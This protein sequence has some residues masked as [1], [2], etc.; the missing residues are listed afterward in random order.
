MDSDGRDSTEDWLVSETARPPTIAE[1]EQRIDEALAAAHATESAITTIG[2]AAIE[3]TEQA[4]AAVNQSLRAAEQAHR[5]AVL[6]ELASS[7]LLDD[8]HTRL[9]GVAAKDDLMRSFSEHA[10]RVTARL[11]ALERLPA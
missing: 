1:L 10:D 5:S 2:D 6:A 4:R 9:D 7:A 11:R 3:A 8:R